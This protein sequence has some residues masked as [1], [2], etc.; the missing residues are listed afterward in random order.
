[1][2][3][4]LNRNTGS[5]T[6]HTIT[7]VVTSYMRNY[8]FFSRHAHA[9]SQTRRAFTILSQGLLLEAGDGTLEETFGATY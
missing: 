7:H 1:M 6:K 2:L 8:I 3:V 4:N 5:V 9:D